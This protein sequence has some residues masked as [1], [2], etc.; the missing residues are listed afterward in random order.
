VGPDIAS[1]AEASGYLASGLVFLTFCMKTMIAL[2]V[3][4]IG[5]NIAFVTYGLFADLTPI[6]LLH[7]VLLPLNV[8]RLWQSRTLIREVRKAANGDLSL[9]WLTPYMKTERRRAGELL[10]SKGEIA[11]KMYVVSEGVV[12]VEEIGL[13]LE[14]GQVFGE[15]SLFSRDAR[16]TA[17]IRCKTDVTLLAISREKVLELYYQNPKFG[18][19]LVQ[20]ITERLIENAARTPTAQEAA[21]LSAAESAAAE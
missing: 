11:D 9:A 4:A 7:S 2:R 12:T 1:I 18:F 13:D 21:Q 19:Y 16:R 10:F 15:I 3:I 20:L 6:Y 5:S 8:M 17:G 14:A